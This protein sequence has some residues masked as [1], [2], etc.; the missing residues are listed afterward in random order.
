MDAVIVGGTVVWINGARRGFRS[1]SQGVSVPIPDQVVSRFFSRDDLENTLFAPFAYPGDLL[2]YA[3]GMA[4]DRETGKVIS[5]AMHPLC[6]TEEQLG[7]L[8]DQLV[9]I[10][11][12]LGVEAT[13]DF[14]RLNEIATRCIEN[15]QKQKAEMYYG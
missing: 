8:R 7:I 14:A 6:G 13:A 4:V 11:N 15:G 5:E 10:L 12:T 3:E 9:Q 2:T 1:D